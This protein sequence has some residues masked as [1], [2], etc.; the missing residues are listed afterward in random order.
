ML[1][2]HSMC[3]GAESVYFNGRTNITSARFLVFGV[4]DL[5]H[6]NSSVKDALSCST[7]LTYLL[8]DQLLTKGQ[9]RGRPG[10][11]PYLWLS[12]LTTIEYIRNCLKR[13]RKRNSA[14][15][16]ASQKPGGFRIS[17]A[18]GS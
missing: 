18:C 17:R 6:A 1:G 5:I 12:N 7:W 9:H 8:S 16:L 2:L 14:L 10:R 15:I 13:V 11:A 3:R 4:K